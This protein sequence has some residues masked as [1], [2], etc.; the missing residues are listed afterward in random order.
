VRQEEFQDRV[1]RSHAREIADG[2]R[3][4]FGKNWVRY[5]KSIDDRK[6]A[7]ARASLQ[8]MLGMDQLAGRSFVDIGSGSGLFSLA[9]R[10]LG[11]TVT[12]FDYDPD[13]VACTKELRRRFSD[14]DTGWNITEGSV[15]DVEFLRGLGTFDIVYSWGVL[16]HTGAMWKAM[17]NVSTL[18]APE[19][20][21]WISIYNDQ[22]VKSRY[23][24]AV[25]RISCSGI[26]QKSLIAATFIP[27]FVGGGLIMDIIRGHNP[28]KRYLH[29]EKNRGMSRVHDWLDWLGGYPFEVAKPEAVFEYLKGLGFRLEQ[30]KTCAGGLGCNE[31]VFVRA[32]HG[33]PKT[34]VSDSL[35]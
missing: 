14:G 1:A 31:Y 26:I 32:G 10:Q 15:L 9:A 22:G 27:A 24:T 2:E 16:H 21:M 5:L 18:V 11:A 30:L 29:Y 8:R 35:A 12:S 13:S 4:S 6:I 19:G 33:G 25:K 3:F 34:G 20:V 28:V 7:E 17:R 23:W